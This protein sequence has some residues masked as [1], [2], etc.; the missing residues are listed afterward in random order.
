MQVLIGT[1]VLKVSCTFSWFS[2]GGLINK[3]SAVD[4]LRRLHRCL[5]EVFLSGLAGTV[6]HTWQ[7]HFAAGNASL[8]Q[9]RR[10]ECIIYSAGLFISLVEQ[11]LCVE[12]LRT[13][14][15]AAQLSRWHFWSPLVPTV[16]TEAH[17]KRR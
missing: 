2:F 14:S 10:Q 7:S 5:P 15:S 1:I 13:C 11:I 4:L 6:Y 8:S 12:K 3:R 9:L 16:T 17:Q